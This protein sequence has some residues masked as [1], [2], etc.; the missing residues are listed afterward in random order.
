MQR[1]EHLQKLATEVDEDGFST[2]VNKRPVQEG[3]GD[4]DDKTDSKPKK[5]KAAPD[6]YQFQVNGRN[7]N[8]TSPA[9]SL[10]TH[11]ACVL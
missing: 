11:R 1:L 5:A 7:T 8:R 4:A 9:R 2:V 6:F 10:A 3:S